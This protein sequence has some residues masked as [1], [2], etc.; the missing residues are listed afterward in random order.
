MAERVGGKVGAWNH[1]D[2]QVGDELRHNRVAGKS[3]YHFLDWATLDLY[4]FSPREL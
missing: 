2:S 3:L 1:N 4:G